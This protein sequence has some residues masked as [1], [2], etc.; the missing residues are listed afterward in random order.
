MLDNVGVVSVV[1]LDSSAA[2][3][4]GFEVVDGEEA[5]CHAGMLGLDPDPTVDDVAGTRGASSA[6]AAILISLSP[7]GDADTE[8]ANGEPGRPAEEAM[9]AGDAS[10]LFLAMRSVRSDLSSACNS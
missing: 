3:V 4:S 9:A 2:G 10:G 5:N 1:C 8:E 7:C 6:L